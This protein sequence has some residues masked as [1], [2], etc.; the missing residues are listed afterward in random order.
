M[1]D[2]PWIGRPSRTQSY[3]LG[4]ALHLAAIP[5]EPHVQQSGLLA[6]H[7]LSGALI[8]MSDDWQGRRLDTPPAWIR[9]H[10]PCWQL[11]CL[12]SPTRSN[13][14]FCIQTVIFSSRI[15][16][17]GCDEASQNAHVE[18]DRSR[19]EKETLMLPQ[20]G[21]VVSKFRTAKP[22]EYA[23]HPPIPSVCSS[24]AAP[25]LYQRQRRLSAPRL[26]D[27]PVS[28]DACKRTRCSPLKIKQNKNGRHEKY[29]QFSTPPRA[30][31][32][33]YPEQAAVVRHPST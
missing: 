14:S 25:P 3:A 18:T 32:F 19:G 28:Q 6:G 8:I 20:A 7:L 24:P 22:L 4:T 27:A 17:G 13:L 29:E 11:L 26:I 2:G 33:V 23:K 15:L 31:V 12:S 1:R 5:G 16:R 10:T 21:G 9:I 30:H